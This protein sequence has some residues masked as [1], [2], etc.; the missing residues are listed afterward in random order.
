MDIDACLRAPDD[1]GRDELY[2][3]V[4]AD[5]RRAGPMANRE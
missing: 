2:R 3:I 4:V 1:A 5:L